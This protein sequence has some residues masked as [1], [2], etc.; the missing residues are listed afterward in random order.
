M[1]KIWI[2][3]IEEVRDFESFQN[4]PIAYRNEEDARKALKVFKNR[5]QEYYAEEIEEEGWI[6]EERDFWAEVYNEDYS[7]DHYLVKLTCVDLQ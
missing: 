3:T 1:E 6:Y 5:I 2:I 7:R 4:S